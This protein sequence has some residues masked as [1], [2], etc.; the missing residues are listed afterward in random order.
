MSELEATHTSAGTLSTETKSLI[1]ELKAAG[2]SNR[3]IAR[4]LSISDHTVAR[5]LP[6]IVTPAEQ[7]VKKTGELN[8]E[9]WLTWL[10]QGQALKKKASWSGVDGPIVLGD[11]TSPQILLMLGDTHISSWGTDHSLLRSALKEIKETEG[12]WVALMGD[13]IQMSIKM[14]SVLEVSDNMLPPEQQADFLEALLESI[15]DKIAFSSWDNHAVEREEKQSGISHIKNL[16]SRRSVYFNGI[17]HPDVKV[18][19]QLYKLACSHKFTGNSMFDSTFGP[20]RYARMEAADREIIL[21]A[22]LHRPAIS[23]YVEGG[24]ERIAITNGSFQTNSGY[25]KRYFSLRTFPVMPCL[26][27]HNDVHKAVPFWNLDDALKYL[28]K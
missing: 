23:Q 8:I 14:R 22:D 24:M 25:A 26:V 16:L 6:K 2:L 1:L 17:G 28:G 27:L 21:Q 5:H 19:T 4:Q 15:I 7:P 9:E 10:E 3:A 20:K 12:L 11:G 13:L 18:G